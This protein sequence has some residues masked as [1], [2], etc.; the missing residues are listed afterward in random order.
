MFASVDVETSVN[1]VLE[2]VILATNW[3]ICSFQFST[4]LVIVGLGLVHHSSDFSV[5]G[6]WTFF[7]TSHGKSPCDGIGGTLKRLTSDESL[8]RDPDDAI[9][10]A[11]MMA[12]HCRKTF[13]TISICVISA[14][15][16]KVSF[17]LISPRYAVTKTYVGTR[18]YHYFEHI[19]DGKIGAKIL[20]SDQQFEKKAR[21]APV[22]FDSII[23][24]LQVGSY[25][26]FVYDRKW[27][28]GIV[29]DIERGDCEVQV[30]SMHPKGPSTSFFW[31]E[32]VDEVWVHSSQILCLVD[33]P[34]MTSSRGF[35]S[36]AAKSSSDIAQAWSTHKF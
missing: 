13:P 17:D 14:E 19:G 3:I 31:P 32:R 34:N 26:A 36:L 35:Y 30:S 28:V 27:Y 7:A 9:I 1:N 10:T 22:L 15:D 20:S 12:E 11:N 25:L 5:V 4:N 24:N 2:R 21:H 23:N 8:R 6:T 18:S 29:E 33:S 16:L